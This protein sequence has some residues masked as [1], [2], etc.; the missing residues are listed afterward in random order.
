MKARSGKNSSQSF[1]LFCFYS[2]NAKILIRYDSPH[3]LSYLPR[4]PLHASNSTWH[5]TRGCH[6]FACVRDFLKVMKAVNHL[7][8]RF[9]SVLDFIS[10]RFEGWCLSS[11]LLFLGGCVKFLL[12]STLSWFG[13]CLCF[14]YLFLHNDN[15]LFIL[16]SFLFD[17]F[18]NVTINVTVVYLYNLA[19]Y[20]TLITFF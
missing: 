18:H 20:R 3:L 19:F 17:F 2:K 4:S 16:F 1:L 5:L 8:V 13:R 11:V 6:C 12:L 10:V 9:I 7:I 15:S 14:I